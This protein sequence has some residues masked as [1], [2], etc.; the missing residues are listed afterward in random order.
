MTRVRFA[1]MNVI[2]CALGSRFAAYTRKYIH[3]YE[4]YPTDS[5]RV[6]IVK[7]STLS[8]HLMTPAV[9]GVAFATAI[10]NNTRY[11]RLLLSLL[12]ITAK[13]EEV[14]T[15]LLLVFVRLWYTRD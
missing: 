9:F 13:E 2:Q 3:T 7:Y 8:L 12:S 1:R 15:Y 5:L 11:D 14:G 4:Q 10:I 6:I